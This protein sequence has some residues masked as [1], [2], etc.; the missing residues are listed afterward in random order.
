MGSLSS[1]KRKKVGSVPVGVLKYVADV[2]IDRYK[3]H[4]VAKVE[5]IDYFEKFSSISKMNSIHLVL[6]LAT[7]YGWI[8][9]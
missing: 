9:F 3:A 8:V 2:S 1:S 4:L 7:S 5:T 6:S